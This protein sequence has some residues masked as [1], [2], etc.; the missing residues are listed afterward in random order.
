MGQQLGL[1]EMPIGTCDHMD[2]AFALAV[3]TVEQK[4]FC[5]IKRLSELPVDGS[6]LA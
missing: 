5:Q 2:H 3:F 1:I 6:N 4:H